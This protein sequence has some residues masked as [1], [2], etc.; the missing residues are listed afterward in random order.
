VL[1]TGGG[2]GGGGPGSGT[3]SEAGESR[4]TGGWDASGVAGGG[5]L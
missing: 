1:V 3:E 5:W 4:G 2:G